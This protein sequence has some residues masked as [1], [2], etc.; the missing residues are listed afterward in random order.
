MIRDTFTVMVSYL[1]HNAAA[2]AAVRL[3]CRAWDMAFRAQLPVCDPITLITQREWQAAVQILLWP[4]RRRDAAMFA[5]DIERT[6]TSAVINDHIGIVKLILWK[7]PVVNVRGAF[8]YCMPIST[9]TE[10][11]I[12]ALCLERCHYPVI[13]DDVVR[14]GY[15]ELIPYADR[16]ESFTGVLRTIIQRSYAITDVVN[17]VRHGLDLC[18]ALRWREHPLHV[19]KYSLLRRL[20]GHC[21][22]PPSIIRRLILLLTPRACTKMYYYCTKQGDPCVD[23]RC[24]SEI[25]CVYRRNCRKIYCWVLRPL[26]IG[27]ALR[28][29]IETTMHKIC[30]DDV[31]VVIDMSLDE[32]S[33]LDVGRGIRITYTVEAAMDVEVM[34]VE[35]RDDGVVSVI[36]W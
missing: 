16:I 2:A 9:P 27:L 14:G 28:D 34:S 26:L 23:S 30:G 20:L 12:A 15:L 18:D 10:A 36:E 11:R 5:I 21:M 31:S 1:T 22:L 35:Q 6:L 29:T 24:T 32:L 17:I 3:T 7:Y 8:R 4:R 19:I 33:R 25:L 13:L